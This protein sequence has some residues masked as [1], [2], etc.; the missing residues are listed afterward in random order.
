MLG[1]RTF[2]DPTE[3]AAWWRLLRAPSKGRGGF[4]VK[5]NIRRQLATAVEK[6]TA[7]L[8]AAEGG[9]APLGDGPEFSAGKIHYAIAERNQAITCGGIGAVH[10]LANKVGLVEA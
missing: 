8:A 5:Q 9:Q 3:G 1:A 10:Q 7:R 6:I 2:W 4:Q